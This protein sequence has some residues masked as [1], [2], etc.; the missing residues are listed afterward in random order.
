MWTQYYFAQIGFLDLILD[1]F[2]MIKM[3]THNIILLQNNFIY[4]FG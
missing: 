2:K 1:Y 4:E 3:Q